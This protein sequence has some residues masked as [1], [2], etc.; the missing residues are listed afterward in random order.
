MRTE[1]RIES[2]TETTDLWSVELGQPP[3]RL[4][5]HPGR[6]A[7][8]AFTST[9]IL[10]FERDGR[11]YRLHRGSTTFVGRGTE[12]AWAPRGGPVAFVRDGAI[13]VTL[14]GAAEKVAAGTSPAWS[15]DGRRLVYST[16][17]GL[18]VLTLADGQRRRLTSPGY[19]RADLAPSV[20]A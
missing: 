5:S 18:H 14:G 7:S 11:I 3:R 6:E 15:P 4:T 13:H 16:V 19:P 8:P 9:G 10:S 2:S 12:P 17:D 20:R 1:V